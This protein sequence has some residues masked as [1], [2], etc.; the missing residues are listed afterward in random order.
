MENAY[1]NP[2]FSIEEN[3]YLTQECKDKLRQYHIYDM[4]DLYQAVPLDDKYHI[5]NGVVVYSLLSDKEKTE[6][7]EK[8]WFTPE[9]LQEAKKLD[10]EGDN[11]VISD[12]YGVQASD[13]GTLYDDGDDYPLGYWLD[14]L[15]DAFLQS[16]I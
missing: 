6:L 11:A 2:S 4:S 1:M 15:T 16:L 5:L 14:E 8:K 10:D 3:T 9:E 7:K 13:F 12:E